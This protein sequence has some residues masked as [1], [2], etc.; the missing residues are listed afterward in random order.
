MTLVTPVARRDAG[1]WPAAAECGR[2]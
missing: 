2:W 1:G